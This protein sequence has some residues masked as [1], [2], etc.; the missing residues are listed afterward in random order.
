[1]QSEKRC[2]F[3]DSVPIEGDNKNKKLMGRGLARADPGKFAVVCHFE[4]CMLLGIISR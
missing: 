4:L 3:K 2:R 1:M